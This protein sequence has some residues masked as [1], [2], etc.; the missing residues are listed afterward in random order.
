MRVRAGRVGEW[1]KVKREGRMGSGRLGLI[2]VSSV[3]WGR[4]GEI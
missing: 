1:L 2:H 4:E 3:E